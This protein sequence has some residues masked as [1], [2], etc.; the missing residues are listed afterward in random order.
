[1]LRGNVQ[2]AWLRSIVQPV[3]DSSGRVSY[4]TTHSSDLTRTIENSREH[5]NLIEALQ[6]ST[7]VIEFNLN[8][9]VL[10]ATSVF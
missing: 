7:A 5:E 1:M 9:Q 6:R 8:G 4:F 3:R 10:T 2:E